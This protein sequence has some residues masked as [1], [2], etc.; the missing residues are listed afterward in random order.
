M[1][2]SDWSSDVCSSDL[3]ECK[4]D[5]R[6][7]GRQICICAFKKCVENLLLAHNQFLGL[8]KRSGIRDLAQPN[9]HHIW[10]SIGLF[11]YKA[12][13]RFADQILNAQRSSRLQYEGF[14]FF[15][16]HTQHHDGIVCLELARK[17]VVSGKSGA[18]R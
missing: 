9:L 2:I 1:R 16:P 6:C 3:A 13:L 18:S 10:M 12:A 5:A 8:R 15:K 17:S 14:G 7:D 4:E 11:D